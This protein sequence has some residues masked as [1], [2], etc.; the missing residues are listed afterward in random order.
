MTESAISSV[1]NQYEELPYPPCDPKDETKR[2]ARTWLE[3]LPKINHYCFGGRN[4]FRNKFRVLVAGGGTGDASIFLAHQLRNTDAH[5]VHLD[6]SSAS[7]A[8]AQERAR[9]RGLENISWIND[10]LLNLPGLGLEK[11]DYINCSGVL[12]HLPD[13]DAGLVALKSVLKDSGALGIMVYA[14]YGRTGVYQLQSLLR[15]VSDE[16]DPTETKLRHAKDILSSLPPTNWFMRAPDLHSDHKL[17]DAG[18]YDLLLHSQDRAYCVSELFEWIEDQH[19]LTIE[20]TDVYTGRSSYLP[21]MRIGAKKTDVLQRIR[22]LPLRRQYAIAEILTGR[23]ITHSFYATSSAACK[24]PYGDVDYV[25]M[26]FH[27]PTTGPMMEKI[28]NTNKNKGRTFLLQHAQ[29][30]VAFPV[31]PG[32]YGPRILREI[33]G[34]KSFKEIFDIVRDDLQYRFDHPTDETLFAD[35]KE[36]FDALSSMDRLLLRHRD[37]PLVE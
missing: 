36:S 12:H 6:L 28:F 2:L 23:I 11:F 18:I 30:G 1:R 19:G 24:A 26:F 14:S 3:D 34:K 22:S 25:P 9:I 33:D 37:A 15:L 31:N 5:V 20:L 35:F 16:E 17:G 4:S 13:P 8:I 21:H 10:S 32:K 27:E 7:I 29:A